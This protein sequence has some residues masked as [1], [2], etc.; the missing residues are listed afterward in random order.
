[1]KSVML[2]IV[3]LLIF[4]AGTIFS[5]STSASVHLPELSNDQKWETAEGNIVYFIIAGISFAKSNGHSAAEFGTWTGTIGLPYW[6]SIE[7]MTLE[8]LVQE[9]YSNEAQFKDLKLEILENNDAVIKGRMK[10]FG[11]KW[12]TMMDWGNVSVEEYKQFFNYKWTAIA[13][14]LGYD[15]DQKTEGEWTY[16]TFRKHM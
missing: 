12:L 9:F 14:G 3:C 6:K 7:G 1:M 4:T 10:G 5:Q 11:I 13:N 15:F 16:F 2:T 8:K